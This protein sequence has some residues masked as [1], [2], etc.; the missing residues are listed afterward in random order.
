[1]SR[2]PEEPAGEV[3]LSRST[4]AEQREALR[5]WRLTDDGMDG[6]RSSVVAERPDDPVAYKLLEAADA[7]MSRGDWQRGL[8][9]LR[10]VVRDY[11][12]SQEAALAR[13]AI[14]HLP[15]KGR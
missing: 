4:D 9:I 12:R 2:V 15:I 7:A 10:L 13:S 11:R 5:L 3:K 14:D 1:M 6:P 8:N